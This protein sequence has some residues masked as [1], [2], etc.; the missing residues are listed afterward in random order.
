MVMYFREFRAA[1]G[2]SPV[3][4]AW[5]RDEP[6][7]HLFLSP[8]QP[9]YDMLSQR[10][11]DE[12]A[13]R[14][15]VDGVYSNGSSHYTD[16]N[17]NKRNNDRLQICFGQIPLDFI[18]PDD[19]QDLAHSYGFPQER[20]QALEK[21]LDGPNYRLDVKRMQCDPSHPELTVTVK[22]GQKYVYV[23]PPSTYTIEEVRDMQARL[24]KVGE[25]YAVLN[26]T[27]EKRLVRRGIFGMGKK[28]VPLYTVKILADDEDQIGIRTYPSKNGSEGSVFVNEN[29]LDSQGAAHALDMI[30][31]HLFS[32][33]PIPPAL[34]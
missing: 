8:K 21:A 6:V 5:E 30:V 1:K 15:V 29:S 26:P 32:R 22:T 13:E 9:M 2:Q 3:N 4:R 16:V 23:T 24:G 17:G 28:E 11:F 19:R 12:V 20:L 31:I 27:G 34:E 14:L 25:E 33:S 7:G 10:H 18:P